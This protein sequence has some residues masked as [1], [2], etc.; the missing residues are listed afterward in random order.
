MTNRAAPQW[1]T[2]QTYAHR[3]LHSA[4]I[5]ENSK[6]AVEAGVEAGFGIECDVQLSRDK[7]PMVFHDW[8]LDRLTG[9]SGKV[10]ER[11]GGEL[12][13]I[14][15]SESDDLIWTLSDML[16][17]V[18]GRVPVLVE[19]KSLPQFDIGSAC[20]AVEA[21]IRGYDGPLA[22]MSFDPHMG[23]W[24]ASNAPDMPRGLVTT[25]TYDAGFL[26][27]WRQP[28]ALERAQ[29]DFLACDIRDLPNALSEMWRD[30]GRPLLTWTARTSELRRR[31]EAYA[32]AAIAEGEGIE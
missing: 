28:Q 3:G 21:S 8:E 10:A 32:D 4:G 24:F 29:P 14:A 9:E 30:L 2:R 11:S 16:N 15:H 22:V 7:V 31:A 6:S 20:A 17:L 12:C 5:V 1:L 23:E 26:H 27:A 25:D 18:D 13:K 19:I